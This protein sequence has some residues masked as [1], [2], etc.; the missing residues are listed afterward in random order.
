MKVEIRKA[1]E[2]EIDVSLSFEKGIIAT[3][4]PFDA[5]LREGDIHYYDLIELIR[6]PKAE[7]LVAEINKEVI[8]SGYAKIL[9]AKPYEKHNEYV[10]LGFMYV[11]PAF[12]G[13]GV[14]Q[15]IVQGLMDWAKDIGLTEARLEVYAENEVAKRSYLKTGFKPHMLEM[16]LE[17]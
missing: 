10:Y 2:A 11:A 15:K 17:I 12:R 1:L 9:P 7:V 4:R 3:E 16:R 14:S 6:S 13:Q 5:T 8:G